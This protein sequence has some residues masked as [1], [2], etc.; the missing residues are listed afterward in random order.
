MQE[1][2]HVLE[3]LAEREY[4]GT[5]PH[6]GTAQL[7]YVLRPDYGSKELSEIIQCRANHR[8]SAKIEESVM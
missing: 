6:V 5:V 3:S 7:L 4:G 1:K 8:C 2:D